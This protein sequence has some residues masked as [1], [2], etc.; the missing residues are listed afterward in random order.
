MQYK[1]GGHGGLKGG[2]DRTA[3]AMREKSVRMCMLKVIGTRASAVPLRR[4]ADDR[5]VA[6]HAREALAAIERRESP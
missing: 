3:A 1:I 6:R 2:A 5:R 4:A